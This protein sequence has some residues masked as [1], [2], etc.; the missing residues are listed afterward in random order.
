[1]SRCIQLAANGLGQTYPNPMV[2]CVIVHQ[3]RIIAEGWHRRAGGPHAEAEAL[4]RVENPEL[5]K[6]STLY[7]SLEPCSHF[8]KTPPCSD[9]II[10][11][12]VKNV[13]I[14]TMD[15]FAAVAGRGIR[16]LIEAG[17]QVKV[18]IL[19]DDC[20]MLNRRFFTF[21]QKKRP[22]IILK[23]AQSQ[24]GYIAPEAKERN[25]REPVWISNSFSKQLVHKWR[26]EEQGI[27][28][29]TRTVLADNPKL[30]TREWTGNN[31]VRIVLDPK[32]RIPEDSHVFNG[33]IK[34]IRIVGSPMSK[35]Q[36]EP[37]PHYITERIDYSTQVP[38]QI[39][40]IL[41]NHGIQSVIV[42][43]GAITLK[44]FISSGLWDEARIFTG[45]LDLD[46]GVPA[47]KI[48]GRTGSVRRLQQDN[49]RILFHPDL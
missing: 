32:E 24:D 30:D 41:Y 22:Y 37:H 25:S 21:H 45:S 11:S 36:A 12:G 28:V 47:P 35:P 4:N 38:V 13:V 31:P 20:R 27:L 18:G 15:P 19:E 1:M 39:A 42:E 26:S 33:K 34:T 10:A 43:G 40:S 3:D 6:D 16:K 14:G 2:G 29:G 46:G 49:L 7:V 5:L 17:C 44:S 48:L 8:G 9:R 23:W